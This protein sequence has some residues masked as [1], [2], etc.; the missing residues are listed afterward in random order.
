MIKAI[1]DLYETWKDAQNQSVEVVGFA[2][3]CFDN[4]YIYSIY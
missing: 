2:F 4:P 1:R 3:W